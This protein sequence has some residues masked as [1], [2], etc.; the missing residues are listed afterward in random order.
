MTTDTSAVDLFFASHGSEEHYRS[1]PDLI[2][3]PFGESSALFYSPLSRSARILSA[4]SLRLLQGCP[5][6][7]TLD[8]HA[9]RLCRE[10]NASP[11]QLE[12]LRRELADLA[13][14]GLLVSRAQLT[15]RVEGPGR[16]EDVPARIA[17]VGVATR[18]RSASLQA[19]LTS[20]AESVQQH[21]RDTRFVVID[22]ST[23]PTREE[24]RARLDALADRCQV[25]VLHAGPQELVRFAEALA[26]E[27]GLP[28]QLVRFALGDEEGW[29]ISTGGSRNALLL[30]TAGEVL[31]Q[32]DD[33][34]LCRGAPVPEEREGVVLSSA[35]DPTEFW[36][37]AEDETAS[38]DALPVGTDLLGLHE[39]FLGRTVAASIADRRGPLDL[40][41]VTSRFF[42]RLDTGEGRI[43]TTMTGVVGDSGMGSSL[44][45]LI[46]DGEARARLHR[47]E[48]AYR[49]ALRRHHWMRAVPRPTITDGSYCMALNLGL[50]NRQVL[51]PFLPFQR[52]QDGVFG[53]ALTLCCGGCTALLPWMVLH[54]APSARSAPADPWRRVGWLQTGHLVQAMLGSFPLLPGQV[55]PEARLRALGAWVE[56][57]ASC[58]PEDFNEFVRLHVW[59]ALTRTA[60]QLEPLLRRYGGRPGYWA[61]DVRRVLGVLAES[62]PSRECGQPWELAEVFG[63]DQARGRFQDL[64]RRFGRLLQEWPSLVEAAKRLRARGHRLGDS[65]M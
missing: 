34:T 31:L 22:R 10:L 44:P 36:F 13:A 21:G 54:Q 48:A 52:N 2:R 41:A 27:A 33:D 53:A 39:Q 51:P 32:V 45:L 9:A 5:T 24:N 28:L 56:E 19:C 1:L 12:V 6:F 42:R 15:A 38:P 11:V 61:D 20:Y 4:L 49:D 40:D 57:I 30:Q 58:S 7:A 17:T 37:F 26:R 59:N 62:L 23:A 18:D 25:E 43:L 35:F 14:A 50:D 65:T 29:P 46:L 16:T 60:A 47:S 3:F 64:V 55:R 63:P 8:D